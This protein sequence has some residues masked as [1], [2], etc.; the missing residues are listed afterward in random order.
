[1][2]METSTHDLYEMMRS[3]VPVS[4]DVIVEESTYD[5]KVSQEV[6]TH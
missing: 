2:D 6:N 4:Y 5:L 3:R 1:M